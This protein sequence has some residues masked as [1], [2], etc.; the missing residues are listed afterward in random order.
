MRRFWKDSRGVSLT[1]LVIAVGIL[2]TL[3]AVGYGQWN[4]YK[5]RANQGEAKVHVSELWTAASTF[6]ARYFTYFGDWRNLGFQPSG[7]LNY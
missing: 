5:V 1:E 3:G 2:A 7:N 4:Q 6:R